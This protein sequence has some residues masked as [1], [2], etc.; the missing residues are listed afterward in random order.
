MSL[1]RTSPRRNL[2]AGGIRYTRLRRFGPLLLVLA[3]IL[4]AFFPSARD[5]PSSQSEE[6][7]VWPPLESIDGGTGER[8]SIPRIIHQASL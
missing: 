5:A 7:V 1:P 3:L 2:H 4:L 6:P 8:R